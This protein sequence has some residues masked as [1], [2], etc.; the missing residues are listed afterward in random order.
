LRV[1]VGVVFDGAMLVVRATRKCECMSDM[2]DVLLGIQAISIR[3]SLL[4]L[5]LV[6]WRLLHFIGRA[7]SRTEP[8]HPIPRD[9]LQPH[10]HWLNILQHLATSCLFFLDFFLCKQAR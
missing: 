9:R 3:I 6:Y 8:R 4:H 5:S 10:I 7:K 1:R 2:F